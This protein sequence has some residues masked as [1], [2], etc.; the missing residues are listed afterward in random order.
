MLLAATRLERAIEVGE[1]TRGRVIQRR[2]GRGGLHARLQ[3]LQI[4]NL[5]EPALS[6][7]RHPRLSSSGEAGRRARQ[8]QHIAKLLGG[9]PQ[10]M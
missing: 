3:H 4:V 9:D 10:L 8:F 1:L 6:V 5:A 2:L 7:L